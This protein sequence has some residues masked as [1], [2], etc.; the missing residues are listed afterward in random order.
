M[1]EEEAKQR[2]AQSKAS[3][4]AG[5]VLDY[6]LARTEPD[7]AFKLAMASFTSNE[8]YLSLKRSLGYVC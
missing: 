4:S 7:M 3:L 1:T 8:M 5:R 6:W 2:L